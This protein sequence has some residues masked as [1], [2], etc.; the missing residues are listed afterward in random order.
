[1]W[2]NEGVGFTLSLPTRLLTAEERKKWEYGHID[3]EGGGVS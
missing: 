1:M 2:A 3:G